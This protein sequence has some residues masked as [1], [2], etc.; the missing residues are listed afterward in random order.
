MHSF[1]IETEVVQFQIQKSERAKIPDEQASTPLVSDLRVVEMMKVFRNSRRRPYRVRGQRYLFHHMS[2]ATW[3]LRIAGIFE[4]HPRSDSKLHATFRH[5]YHL[6]E[7]SQFDQ[8]EM[9]AFNRVHQKLR[10]HTLEVADMVITTISI[11]GSANFHS[12]FNSKLIVVDETIRAIEPDIWN[13]LEHYVRVL[14]IMIGDAK[15]FRPTVVNTHQ[16]KGFVKNLQ[17]SYFER[18]KLPGHPSVMLTEQYRMVEP[19]GAMISTLFH[20]DKLMNGEGTAVADRQISSNLTNYFKRHYGIASP[21]MILSVRG[22]LEHNNR[23]MYNRINAS[24]GLNIVMNLIDSGTLEADD[25]TI[26]TFYR[27]QR[28]LYLQSLENASS[29][30]PKM[31]NIQVRTVDSM[32]GR[33]SPFIL[34]DTVTTK[35]LRFLQYKNR[36]NV[37]CSRAKDGMAIVAEFDDITRQDEIEC[38]YFGNVLQHIVRRRWMQ[39]LRENRCK[40]IY[41]FDNGY[42]HHE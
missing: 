28:R 37:S 4:S 19:I 24:E 38:R 22:K 25:V 39:R 10:K 15:Q 2:L 26:L 30:K 8:G 7:T 6:T 17:V 1:S 32:Q 11:A 40:S 35:P 21:L 36:I 5:Y 31:R 16:N 9:K 14:L 13:L 18:L 41:A 27:A 33:E 34:L 23:S 20:E 29:A 3:M 42:Y 12:A